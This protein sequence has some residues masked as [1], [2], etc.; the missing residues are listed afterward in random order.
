MLQLTQDQDI[1][2]HKVQ[3][4]DTLS[5]I[6]FHYHGHQDQSR[7][8]GLI[9][10]SMTANAFIKNPDLIYPGQLIQV[11]VPA[12]Y[13]TP[14]MAGFNVPTLK[15]NESSCL[16]P[17]CKNWNEATIEQRTLMPGLIELSLMSSAALAEASDKW[18]NSNAT[19]MG[20]IPTEYE[21]YKAGKIS[22]G[23]YD[24]ARKK[25]I[26]QLE[27]NLKSATGLYTDGKSSREVLRISRTKGK[28][29]TA[30]I[31]TAATK[32]GQYGKA[33]T[34][35]GYVLSAV[36]LGVTCHDI[37]YEVNPVKRS[38]LLVEGVASVGAGAFL[39]LGA[40]YSLLLLATPVGWTAALAIG[41]SIA[42][43][44]YAF[45]KKMGQTY[46]RTADGDLSDSLG[47]SELCS[48]IFIDRN[49]TPI[50]K[51]LLSNTQEYIAP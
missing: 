51:R 10:E 41:V 39:G 25:V 15:L 24:Y 18:L 27:Q 23:Q 16:G 32:L 44:S 4:G 43:A 29:P 38:T 6:L 5:K 3:P 45:G 21:K 22:K 28:A 7:L 12:T 17:V 26:D 42:V 9:A 35:A 11:P 46:E 49:K 47:V 20:R 31:N 37:A 36:S 48:T 8:Q 33:A 34:K 30:D 14:P 40:G 19:L 2:L 1:I 13:K 50:E